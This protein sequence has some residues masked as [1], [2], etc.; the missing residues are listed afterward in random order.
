MLF[1]LYGFL[2]GEEVNGQR[3]WDGNLFHGA[4]N[5]NCI[6]IDRNQNR[7]GEEFF[8]LDNPGVVKIQKA[9]I[10]K[11]V[12]ALN[13]RFWLSDGLGYIKTSLFCKKVDVY[14][15]FLAI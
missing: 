4:N 8:S 11:M 1:E 6:D 10:E 9:Y 14:V 5:I 12:D 13:K 7:L 3:L 2:D 15:R